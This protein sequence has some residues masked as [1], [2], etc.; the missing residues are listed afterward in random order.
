M[1]KRILI[2]L[3][4]VIFIGFILASEDEYNK[5]SQNRDD[6]VLDNIPSRESFAN[7]PMFTHSEEPIYENPDRLI[8]KYEIPKHLLSARQASQNKKK[9]LFASR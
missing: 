4:P 8:F 9:I 1:L 7:V 6:P 2:I 3:F 5:N